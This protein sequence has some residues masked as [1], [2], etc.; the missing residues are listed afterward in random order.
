[1]EKKSV[2]IV[3]SSTGTALS[4]MIKQYTKDKYNHASISLDEELRDM[5]SF[6]RKDPINPLSGG[7]VHEDVEVGTY[8]W[9]PDTEI[10][11]I[12]VNVSSAQYR[13]IVRLIEMFKEQESKYYYNLIG[14]FGVVLNKP[15]EVKNS[16]F[17]SQFVSEIF[18]KSGYQLLEKNSS[19]VKPSDFVDLDNSEVTYEGLLYEYPPI[20]RRITYDMKEYRSFPFRQY[21]YQK[22]NEE[23]LNEIKDGHKLSFRNG[24]LRPKK[25]YFDEKLKWSTFQK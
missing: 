8:S 2:F 21:C 25:I 1:M 11:V 13:E 4:K 12:K 5:Y 19:L 23:I 16:Y 18:R 15:L 9:F 22:M 20:K 14:L 10:R 3:L 17:C 7:F 24:F 6:G